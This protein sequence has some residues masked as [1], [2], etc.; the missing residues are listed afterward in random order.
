[1]RL[2]RWRL[3]TRLIVLAGLVL[4]LVGT[5]IGT[6]S[7]LSVR[8]SLMSDLDAQLTSMTT[9]ARSGGPGSGPGAGPGSDSSSAVDS[10][11]RF[12]FQPGVGDGALAVV[13]S[14]GGERGSSPRQA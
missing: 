10:A 14:G 3:Q 9:H 12:L 1:M 5:G 6:A 7:W 2:R 4:L 8:T 13:D 11:L